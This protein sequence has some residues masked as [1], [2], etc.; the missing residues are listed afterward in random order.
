MCESSRRLGSAKHTVMD[1]PARFRRISY[2]LAIDLAR[3]LARTVDFPACI[4]IQ[5]TQNVLDDC[6]VVEHMS[7]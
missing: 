4:I 5:P 2:Q 7:S 6:S 3:C 1:R